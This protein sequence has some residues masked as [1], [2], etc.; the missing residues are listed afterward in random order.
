MEGFL[1][2]HIPLARAMGVEVLEAAA[3][4]VRLSAPLP[5]NVNHRGTVF[6]GSAA[7]VAILAAWTLLHLRLRGERPDA[8]VVIQKSAMTY[9]CPI[10]GRFTASC[11]FHDPASWSRFLATLL[12]KKRARI[13]L[14]SVLHCD[15]AKVGALEG[16]FV[17]MEP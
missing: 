5:P 7:A 8:S 3:H 10:T 17:A 6:G 16:H 13:R 11:T 14:A 4:C 2:E 9:E 12:R 1:H 15:G